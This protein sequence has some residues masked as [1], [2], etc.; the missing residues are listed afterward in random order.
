M[1]MYKTQELLVLLDEE[2]FKSR[3]NLKHVTYC[4]MLWRWWWCSG[5]AGATGERKEAYRT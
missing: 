3:A 5:G 1:I 2:V 4:R